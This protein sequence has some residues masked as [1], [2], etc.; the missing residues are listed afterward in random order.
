MLIS[1]CTSAGCCVCGVRQSTADPTVQHKPNASRFILD[2]S[3]TETRSLWFLSSRIPIG[4]GSMSR[5]SRGLN[6]SSIKSIETLCQIA[7]ANNR[8]YDLSIH[9]PSPRLI[10]RAI[11]E[12]NN[13]EANKLYLLDSIGSRVLHDKPDSEFEAR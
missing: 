7:M 4:A 3:S 10:E 13:D 8:L 11:L 2:G 6:L 12:S 1:R 9:P 5:L